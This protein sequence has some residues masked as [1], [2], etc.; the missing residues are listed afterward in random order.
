MP[1]WRWRDWR[2]RHC[3]EHVADA[4][5]AAAAATMTGMTAR[6]SMMQHWRRMA[7]G[8]ADDRG[9]DDDPDDGNDSP[10]FGLPDAEGNPACVGANH[11]CDWPG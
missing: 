2:G 6:A 4:A 3:N 11:D 5:T 7:T 8:V 1:R 9:E 10:T